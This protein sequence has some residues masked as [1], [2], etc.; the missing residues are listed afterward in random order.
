MGAF[1]HNNGGAFYTLFANGGQREESA[2]LVDNLVVRV[3]FHVGHSQNK[4]KSV[5]M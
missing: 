1:S 3:S 5:Q 2:F 4:D